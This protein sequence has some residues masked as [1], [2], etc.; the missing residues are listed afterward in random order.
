MLKILI[1]V[2]NSCLVLI[3]LCQICNSDII[4]CG[5]V[6]A[7]NDLILGGNEVSKGAWPFAVVISRKIN[8]KFLCG[9]TLISKKH[10]L[11]GNRMEFSALHCSSAPYE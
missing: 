2:V 6:T 4:E 1:L 10:V 3:G 8:N 11:T 5:T 9:G 7:I